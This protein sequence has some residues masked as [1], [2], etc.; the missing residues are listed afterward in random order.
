MQAILI[1]Y[2]G[3]ATYSNN[4]IYTDPLSVNMLM[5]L[6]L[7]PPPAILIG[8]SHETL[9]ILLDALILLKARQVSCEHAVV[10]KDNL[11]HFMTIGAT[12]NSIIIIGDCVVMVTASYQCHSADHSLMLLN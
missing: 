4:I 1:R 7:S 10:Y 9:L 12:E 6:D 11:H 3:I 8:G 5:T 2:Y